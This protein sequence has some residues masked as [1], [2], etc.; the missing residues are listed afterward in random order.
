M[1]GM[2]DCCKK[3]KRN[4]NE[5]FHE[6]NEYCC[7]DNKSKRREAIQSKKDTRVPPEDYNYIEQFDVE[8]D[9]KEEEDGYSRTSEK[10]TEM[11]LENI[12]AIRV[13]LE[14]LVKEVKMLRAP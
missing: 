2:T 5:T 12:N 1:I 3:D 8:C 7:E 4:P 9:C 6:W 10:N 13:A 14:Q 11:L